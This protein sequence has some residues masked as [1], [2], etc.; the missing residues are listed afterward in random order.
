MLPL[1]MPERGGSIDHLRSFINI[2]TDHDW[3]LIVAALTADFRPHG[4]YPIRAIQG[5]QGSA[6]S[7]TTRVLRKAIDPHVTLLRC[8]PKEVRDL[9]IAATNAWCVVL[10]NLSHLPT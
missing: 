7:T 2:G 5:E 6:K 9:M 8:E 10:D 4:P 3:K 1:P